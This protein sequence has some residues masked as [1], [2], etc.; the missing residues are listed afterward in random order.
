MKVFKFLSVLS[1]AALLLTSCAEKPTPKLIFK[2]TFDSTQTRLDNLGNP[3]VMPANHRGQHPHFNKMSAHYIELAPSMFTALGTGAKLY[4]APETTTG[5]ANAIDFNQSVR[6]GENEEFFSIPLKDVPAGTYEWLR[7]SLAYQNYDI[8]YRVSP[9]A[10]PTV[11]D[12]VG[13]VASFIGYRTYIQNYVISTQSQTINA[14]KDQGFWGFESFGSVVSGQAPPGATT[15][16]NPLFASSPIPAGSCVVT[17]AFSTP[18][19][20]TGSETS[21]IT[22]NVSLSINNS[23]EW[24]EHGG[25]NLYEPLNG[26]TV[27]DMGIRG[28]VPIVQ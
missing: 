13:T 11:F 18:L 26:D 20:I 1:F 22:I 6:V 12:G 25:N 14:N 15:V 17:A 2:F 24:V 9:P 19:T 5:G 10:F 27:I 23:F 28:M 3:A 21:D 7:I 4:I 8:T 16:P